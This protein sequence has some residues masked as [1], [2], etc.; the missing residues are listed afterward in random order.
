MRLLNGFP[1]VAGGCTSEAGIELL[2]KKQAA[3]NE[4][5]HHRAILFF[6]SQTDLS[7]LDD[8]HRLFSTPKEIAQVIPWKI[9]ENETR[10]RG[11]S[12]EQRL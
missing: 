11:L 5:R 9:V 4:K 6:S 8:K 12:P 7:L 2:N 1:L 10:K 3:G